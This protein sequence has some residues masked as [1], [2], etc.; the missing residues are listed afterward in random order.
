MKRVKD[1]LKFNEFESTLGQTLFPQIQELVSASLGKNNALINSM[2]TFK[3]YIFIAAGI[4]FIFLLIL[5]ILI[6]AY[7]RNG[8]NLVHSVFAILTVIC[9]F[10]TVMLW[11]SYSK[12]KRN[13][14]IEIKNNIDV[15][16]LYKI[17]LEAIPAVSLKEVNDD[18]F[19]S[20]SE[21]NEFRNVLVPS[22]ARIF[23][24]NPTVS[25]YLFDKYEAKMTSYGFE[26]YTTVGK[27][28]IRN[29]AWTFYL[30]IDTRL[31]QNQNFDFSFFTHE[32]FFSNSKKAELEN[33]DFNKTFYPRTNDQLK[34]RMLLTPLAMETMLNRFLDTHESKVSFRN[35]SIISRH[36]S[37]YYSLFTNKN[38][39]KINFNISKLDSALI[40]KSIYSDIVYDI[41][42][43]YYLLSFLI[44]PSYLG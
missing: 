40:T 36:N 39:M 18:K 43:L 2:K 32:K 17:A 9:F 13:I 30:K 37:I 4:S 14:E 44:I 19:L 24:K 34:I 41:Y 27:Q 3:R 21:I 7:N 33:K 8:L 35:F 16:D 11:F 15:N 10:V 42:S 1:Y 26:W 20:G 12:K 29:E 6:S 25:V 22:T 38:F 31:L 23:A 28:R 5:L